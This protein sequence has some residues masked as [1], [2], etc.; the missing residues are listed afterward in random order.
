[1][2]SVPTA[3]QAIRPTTGTRED[4]TLCLE[5]RADS[6]TNR[7]TTTRRRRILRTDNHADVTLAVEMAFN[8]NYLFYLSNRPAD[9]V[10]GEM[11]AAAFQVFKYSRSLFAKCKITSEFALLLP[12]TPSFIIK[13]VQHSQ[14]PSRYKTTTNT[15]PH[16]HT[17]TQPPPHSLTHTHTSARAHTHTHTQTFWT[18]QNID[19]M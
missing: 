17:P 8:I 14:A 9:G 6:V 7:R 1:M 12:F 13:A 10:A 2:E 16:T 15:H 3:S 11:K 5:H 4:S 18:N 19:D